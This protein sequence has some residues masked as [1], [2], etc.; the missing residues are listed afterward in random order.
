MRGVP[1]TAGSVAGSIRRS[2]SRLAGEIASGPISETV[3][4]RSRIRPSRSRMPGFSWP[5]GPNRSNFITFSPVVI[6][7]SEAESAVDDMDRPGGEA[8]LVAREMDRQRRDL[9]G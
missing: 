6:S 5:A 2:L 3:P 9:L 4:E 7:G 8:G 1:V